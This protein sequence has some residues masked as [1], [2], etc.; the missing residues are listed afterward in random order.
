MSEESKRRKAG[1][2]EDS[3]YWDSSKNRY[4][5]AIS[6]GYTPAGKRIRVKVSGKTKTEVRAK[7][8]EKR[9]ELAAGIKSSASY[10]IEQAVQAWLSQGLKGRDKGTVD[11]YTSMATHHVIAD[12]GKV[13]LVDLT[14]DGVDCW[15]DEK[16]MSLAKSSMEMILSILRRSITHAQRRD[17]VLRNVAELVEL[18]EGQSGRPSKSL[19]LE[20]AKSV[21]T[22]R[23]GTWVHLYVAVSLLVGIRTEEVRPLTWDRVHLDPPSGTAPH[24]EVWRSVRRRGE[25]KTVKSRRTLAMPKQ[26]VETLRAYQK[27][28]QV[29]RES[30]GLS[31]GDGDFVFGTSSGEQRT[32]E[33]VRRNFRVLLGEA[34]F[35]EPKQWT[36]RELRHSFV[37]I[38]SDHGVPLEKIARLVGHSSSQTTEAVYRKQIRPVITDGAEAMDEIFFRD[39]GSSE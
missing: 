7:I 6:L 10:T 38:L 32:A 31:W 21:L 30:L 28:Q 37:S 29:R 16:S 17:L 4:V 24:I 3:I 14:A 23:Q 25:T 9:K 36:P 18:P 12:L 35:I 34:G 8:R 1:N 27:A 11:T 20:Q 39:E 33:N 2:G 26:L 13:R 22:A 15:L 19:R 5:G